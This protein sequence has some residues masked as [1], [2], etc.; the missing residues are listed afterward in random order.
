MK[1]IKFLYGFI[2]ILILFFVVRFVSIL[3]VS[4]TELKLQIILTNTPVFLFFG[5][6]FLERGLYYS[7]KKGYFNAQSIFKF[8]LGG[9]L[10]LFS[11]LITLIKSVLLLIKNDGPQL[12]MI[13][14]Q[15][16]SESFL[17]LIVGLGLVV[18]SDFIR[19]ANLL[20]GENDLTI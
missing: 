19:K 13:L 4:P 18:I 3:I 11:G 2:I 8:K 14:Q 16:I 5:L 10:F 6:I 15:D 9:Y 20:Q 1:K 12:K 7:I 17:I